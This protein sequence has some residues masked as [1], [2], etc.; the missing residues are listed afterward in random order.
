MAENIPEEAQVVHQ[1]HVRQVADG[2]TWHVPEPSPQPA[3]PWFATAA[4]VAGHQVNGA[5]MFRREGSVIKCQWFGG[6]VVSFTDEAIKAAEVPDSAGTV[7]ARFPFPRPT[8]P[9]YPMAMGPY[10]LS[11]VGYDHARSET[12]AVYVATAKTMEDIDRYVAGEPREPDAA[13]DSSVFDVCKSDV[14]ED[15]DEE[16]VE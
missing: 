11:V 2:I 13:I 8:A 7:V 5:I 10:L 12:V 3:P 16:P 4:P 14:P 6:E 1:E 15:Q 9:V